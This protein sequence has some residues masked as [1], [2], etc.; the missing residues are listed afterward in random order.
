MQAY[1]DQLAM[2]GVRPCL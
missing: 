1:I 2:V